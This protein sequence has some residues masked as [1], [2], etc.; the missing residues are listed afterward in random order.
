MDLQP[1]LHALELDLAVEHEGYHVQ[2]TGRSGRMVA[3]FPSLSSLIHFAR[4]A[5]PARH[6]FPSGLSIRIEWRG[7]GFRVKH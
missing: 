3:R 5:F 6:Q 7:M 2:V 4:M 1:L